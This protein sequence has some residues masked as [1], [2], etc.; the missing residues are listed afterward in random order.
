MNHLSKT[1]DAVLV[2]EDGTAFW[3]F[4]L[5][6]QGVKVGELCFNTAMTGY[7]E[8]ITDLSYAGQIITFTFPHI[9]NVGTNDDDIEATEN[10]DIRGVVMREVPTP[11]SNWRAR[12]DFN[13]WLV[14]CGII[15]I[16]GIDTR[17]ITKRLRDKG[18]IKAA[19]GFGHTLNIEELQQQ[20]QD[21]EGLVNKNCAEEVSTKKQKL[22]HGESEWQWNK[23]L[24]H[25]QTKYKVVAFDYGIKK[26]ILRLFTKYNCSVQ[27]VPAD[28]SAEGILSLKPDGLFLSNG[29]G[30]PTA[31]G[32]AYAIEALQKIIETEVPIF[33]ICLGHQLL[34]LALGGQTQKMHQGHHGANH[35]VQN[36]ATG[37]VEITSMNHGWTVVRESLPD[38][39][40]ETHVS[41]FDGTNCGL[42][43]K[44]D[45][46]DNKVF[47][48]QYHPE[49]SPGPKDSQYLFRQ[50]CNIMESNKH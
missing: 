9:G 35:P 42:A 14:K 29:P 12:E 6:A 43:L 19:I 36:L 5:G 10:L 20:A 22:W 26:N 8:I 30:D 48:V 47:S 33:G 28:T 39:V 45:Q 2:L 44:N 13:R 41:L 16:A 34:A 3:G 24:E 18:F 50:F 23:K 25:T 4:G 40:E 1:R 38:N 11:P 7:Q 32:A 46:G 31:T 17:E 21:W 49:A 15:G 37:Q 27:I